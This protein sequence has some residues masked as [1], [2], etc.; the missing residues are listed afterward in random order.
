MLDQ[1]YV[2]SGKSHMLVMYLIHNNT[3]LLTC[4]YEFVFILICLHL[5]YMARV[6]ILCSVLDS[7]ISM[8]LDLIHLFHKIAV[9]V[10]NSIAKCSIYVGVAQK[11]TQDP[12]TL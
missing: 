2:D 11:C 5:H 4:H 12:L 9:P 6:E 7:V 10:I 1:D 3:L 8:K